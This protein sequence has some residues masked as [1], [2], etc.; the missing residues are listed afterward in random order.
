MVHGVHN[1]REPFVAIYSDSQAALKALQSAKT[2]SS[3]VAILPGHNNVPGNEIADELQVWLYIYRR[4]ISLIYPIFSNY[5]RSKMS[6]I[7]DIFIFIEFLFY[8]FNVT[9]CDY[10]LIFSPCVLLALTCAVS[11][12]SVLDNF[13]QIAPLYSNAV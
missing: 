11:F 13:C 10:V 3:L 12:F 8:F 1:E 6:D 2:R 4:Y 5:F 9:H 7:F